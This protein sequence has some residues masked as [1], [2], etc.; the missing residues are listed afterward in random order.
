MI[1]PHNLIGQTIGGNELRR[2]IASGSFSDVYIGYQASLD[3]EVAVK[4]FLPSVATDPFRTDISLDKSGEP[5][6]EE[7]RLEKFIDMFRSEAKLIAKLEH[8]NIVSVYDYGVQK[9]SQNLPAESN[10]SSDIQ[11]IYIAMRLLTGM[12]LRQY[13]REPD[14]PLRDIVEIIK[15]IADGLNYAHRQGIIHRDIK[16]DNVIFDHRD[17]PCIADFGL[18]MLT[19]KEGET[20]VAGTLAYMTPEMLMGAKPSPASD[21]YAL[22]MIAYE[23]VSGHYPYD[24]NDIQKLLNQI[25]HYLPPPV[26]SWRADVPQTIDSVINRAIAKDATERYPSVSDFAHA[27]AQAIEVPPKTVPQHLFISYSRRDKEYAQKLSI[28]LQENNFKVWIDSQIDYGDRWF[29]EIEGA[30]KSCGAFLVIMTPDSYQSEWV[31]KEILLAKRSKKPIFPML[32]SGEE[33]G[34]LIDIQ[35]ADVREEKMPDTDF[36][37]RLRHTVF[38][39]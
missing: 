23:M 10:S 4:V 35:Y 1:N 26:S 3:R 14:R 32:L 30:I 7:Q 18:A 6:G 27:F 29:D 19:E 8:P 15:Q 25:L 16:P 20:E 12:S 13:M 9:I 39:E 28:H 33:F 5:L 36:H 22:G 34:V 38:G 2:K 21:Q 37:R 31:K 24:A 11:I 17:N